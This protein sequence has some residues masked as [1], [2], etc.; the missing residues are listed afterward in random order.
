MKELPKKTTGKCLQHE[1]RTT[2]FQVT[3]ADDQWF[4]ITPEFNI[5]YEDSVIRAQ[6]QAEQAIQG[7]EPDNTLSPLERLEHLALCMERKANTTIETTQ[8]EIKFQ[9]GLRGKIGDKLLSY[10][11]SGTDVNTTE[12][13]REDSISLI[14]GMQSTAKVLFESSNSAVI[15]VNYFILESQCEEVSKI[16]RKD[17]QGKRV[18]TSSQRD[19]KPVNQLLHRIMSLVNN[20]GIPLKSTFIDPLL[21]LRSFDSMSSVQPQCAVDAVGESHCQE[22][23]SVLSLDP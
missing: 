23:K 8:E 12:P 16:A 5:E 19:R 3:A 15:L 4:T 18:V 17:W 10:A 20:Y 6:K 14:K 13:L 7:C 2:N 9:I 21:Q 11:C 1:C 22:N